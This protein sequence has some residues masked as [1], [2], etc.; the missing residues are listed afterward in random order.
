MTYEVLE[1]CKGYGCFLCENDTDMNFMS[2]NITKIY[3][4]ENSTNRC[5]PPL[6]G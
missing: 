6:N 2:C 3:Y 4:Q 5:F 1:R